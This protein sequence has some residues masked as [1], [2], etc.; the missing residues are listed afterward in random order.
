MIGKLAANP[1]T[2]N[3]YTY[4]FLAQGGEQV[5]EQKLDE[6]EDIEIMI[7]SLDEV[8]EMLKQQKISQALH[9]SCIFY[10]FEKLGL[11]SY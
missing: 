3:N 10:A 6:T 5:A 9:T 4:F 11:I 2:A 1:A 8:K 7:V